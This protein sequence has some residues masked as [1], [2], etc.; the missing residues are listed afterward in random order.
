MQSSFTKHITVH[1]F[2][3]IT[4]FPLIYTQPLVK[5]TPNALCYHPWRESYAALSSEESCIFCSL[6]RNE[7]DNDNFILYR[8]TYHFVLLNKKPY[9]NK[10][11][12]FLVVPY[13][14]GKHLNNLSPDAL[15]EMD[16]ITQKICVQF[17]DQSYEIQLNYNIGTYANASI[18]NH[19]H[20]HIICDENPR[21]YNIIDAMNTSTNPI[22]N[23]IKQQQLTPFFKSS[24]KSSVSDLKKHD[25]H[26]YYCSIL[27]ENHDEKNLIIHRGKQATILFNHYPFCAGEI[28]IIPNHHYESK[29]HMPQDVA[30]ELWNFVI[31]MYPIIL[32]S[33][34]AS[35]IT[36]GMI[37][38][39]QKSMDKKHIT[40]HLT[41]RH[42]LPA[43]SPI[44]HTHYISNDLT[45][46]HTELVNE[47][48]KLIQTTEK[49]QKDRL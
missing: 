3:F 16:E 13:Q 42:S 43:I 28:L 39:G 40:Y 17:S 15:I 2:Y 49:I 33:T 31:K 36:L 20:Q 7:N 46:L 27:N 35:D 19:L 9:V 1:L 45:K 38:Y 37:S 6:A 21:Y 8:G 26:C 10:G 4:L 47:W 24:T 25:E 30:Q 11:F 18:P 44:M 34:N 5:T 22:D 32:S 14:H 41:P 23:A 12:H 29:E 48:N